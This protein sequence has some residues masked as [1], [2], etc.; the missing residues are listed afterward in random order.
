MSPQ[1]SRLK[2]PDVKQNR[3]ALLHTL[4]DP[5]WCPH[6]LL[7]HRYSRLCG[8]GHHR[9]RQTIALSQHPSVE[10]E[11]ASHTPREINEV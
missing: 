3:F 5:P 1:N 6:K 11:L 7:Y 10:A 9:L 4:P 8:L 2:L